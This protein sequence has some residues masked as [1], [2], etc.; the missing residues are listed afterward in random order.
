MS[1]YQRVKGHSFER[2]IARELKTLGIDAKRVL[3]YQE[4]VGHDVEEPHFVYQCKKGKAINVKASYKEMSPP[5]GKIGAVV[6]GWDRDLTLVCMTWEDFK[7][8]RQWLKDAKV[9]N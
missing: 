5:S 7:V 6:A 1:K 3:E 8:I 9:L 4:G 2:K